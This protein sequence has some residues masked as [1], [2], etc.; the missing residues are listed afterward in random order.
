MSATPSPKEDV[1]LVLPACCFL[2]LLFAWSSPV[3][4]YCT[5]CI[6]TGRNLQARLAKID[7]FFA[8]I[9]RA[10]RKTDPPATKIRLYS[11]GV[12]IT[13]DRVTD[14][15]LFDAAMLE[16]KNGRNHG[17]T[18]YRLFGYPIAIDRSWSNKSGRIACCSRESR[19]A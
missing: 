14:R 16:R 17:E 19:T 5:V 6:S 3:F 9:C 15:K 4:T 13:L 12:W 11:L 8:T 18:L 2:L 1:C 7:V 10:K